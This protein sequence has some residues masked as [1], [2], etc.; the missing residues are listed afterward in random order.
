MVG[1]LGVLAVLAI[2]AG[3]V[4]FDGEFQ[5]WVLGALPGGGEGH[6]EWETGI[7]IGSTVLAV[8][9]MLLA[10]LLYL[11][12]RVNLEA[13]R[14]VWPL[15]ELHRFAVR[16]YFADAIGETLLVRHLFYAGIA[17]AASEFDR[18]VVDGVVNQT[19]RD[20]VELG[21]RARLVQNG[22]VQSGTVLLA[23]GSV[24]IWASVVIF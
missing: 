23:L 1:V 6:F 4:T 10:T 22:W 11:R 21:R 7:F 17:R 2:V 20:V 13:V 12:P 3:F 19:G 16:K 18:L 14:G 8:A 24:V 5:T 15:R 9:G